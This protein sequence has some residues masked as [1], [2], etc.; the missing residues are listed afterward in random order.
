MIIFYHMYSLLFGPAHSDHEMHSYLL[1]V[2]FMSMHLCLMHVCCRALI[3]TS[4]FIYEYA[5]ML[6]TSSCILILFCFPYLHYCY[7][8]SI[9]VFCT[10]FLYYLPQYD[11]RI[12]TWTLFAIALHLNP[13][14]YFWIG[15]VLTF[16]SY[17]LEEVLTD[18]SSF[19]T[20]PSASC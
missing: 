18:Q 8:A 19:L 5:S 14:L 12:M 20:M 15:S 4:C 13:S 7:Q 17:E 16:H 9:Y 6:L 10:Y 2:S 3:P 11:S 1:P